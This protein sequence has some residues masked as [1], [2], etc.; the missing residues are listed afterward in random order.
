MIISSTGLVDV[1][2]IKAHRVFYVF[3]TSFCCFVLFHNS[4]NVK[5]KDESQK[6]YF[7]FEMH[8]SER[9]LLNM[10]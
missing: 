8:Q 2:L 4:E 6:D 3:S 7:A 10:E 5:L 1:Q 9:I